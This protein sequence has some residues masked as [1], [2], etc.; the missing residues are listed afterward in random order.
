MRPASRRTGRS[1]G[2]RGSQPAAPGCG[3]ASG[4]G[5]ASRPG[6]R[7]TA[8]S[9]AA[10]DVDGVRAQARDAADGLDGRVV[11]AGDDVRSRDDELGRSDPAATR[12]RRARR[13]CR[14]PHDRRRRLPNGAVGEHP[15]IGRRDRRG[16]PGD[17]R[18]RIDARE[19]AHQLRAAARRRSAAGARTSAARS[20]AAPAVP[21]TAARPRR[22]PRR[23]RAPRRR[24]AGARRRSR[25][26]APAELDLRRRTLPA[27]VPSV[28]SRTAPTAAPASPTSGVYGDSDPSASRC[29][30]SREPRNAPTTM[31]ASESA[32]KMSPFRY[33][34][35][36]E[37][38][39]TG[40]AI[41]STRVTLA[42]CRA[43]EGDP[44]HWAARG[45]VVQLV[46]TP[47]CH[48]GGRGFES[49]R[50][51]SPDK[52]ARFAGSTLS[53]SSL[54]VTAAGNA[55]GGQSPLRCHRM[56]H[57]QRMTRLPRRE[58]TQTCHRANLTA[59]NRFAPVSD[60]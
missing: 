48:A 31:P 51:R 34:K 36:A 13:R 5:D 60:T 35:N 1:P 19:R 20:P 23:P 7:S 45:G 25:T 24:R 41:Q 53:G 33:P 43:S 38:A 21:G 12:R 27:I 6:T 9:F 47:A 46:R 58:L 37:S 40:S 11:L 57:P 59:A 17:R 29:G 32:L 55:L 14:A 10:V 50:S 42:A 44:L 16:G 30:A 2:S 39:T 3:S 8:T 26:P 18:E 22:A 52:V 56:R 28:S 15:R 49:R 54:S 4:S